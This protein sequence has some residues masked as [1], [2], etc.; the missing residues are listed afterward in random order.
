MS[1]LP[2]QVAADTRPGDM[3]CGC[4]WCDANGR[5]TR[6]DAVLL[7][8]TGY[9]RADLVEMKHVWDVLSGIDIPLAGDSG[10]A[11]PRPGRTAIVS[12]LKLIAK[13]GTQSDV[14]VS[15]RRVVR[16]SGSGPGLCFTIMRLSGLWSGDQQL[17]ALQH[18][19]QA[20]RDRL[21]T[22]LESTT[23]SVIV[24]DRNW[25][26]TYA[27]QRAIAMIGRGRS[28][29]GAN[30][31]DVY[32]EA[33]TSV[34]EAR[35]LACLARRTSLEF[36][37]FVPWLNAWLEVHLYPTDDSITAFFRDIS[38]AKA[39]E[40]EQLKTREWVAHMARHDPLTGLPNR[41]LF[42]DQLD[43]AI[44]SAGR[45][46]PFVVLLLDV[47]RFGVVNT[48]LG[49]GLGDMVLRQIGE[50]LVA[51]A[52]DI[53]IVARLGSDEFG[54]ILNGV[55]RPDDAAV[56]ANRIL[57]VMADPITVDGNTV[58]VGVSIGIACGISDGSTS[59]HLLAHADIALHQVKTDGGAGFRFASRQLDDQLRVRERTK[60]DLQ[61]ALANDDLFLQY[62]PIVQLASRRIVGVEALVR[63]RHRVLGIQ[64]PNAFIPI[65]EDSGLIVP[66]GRWVLRQAARD[67]ARLPTDIVVSV[68]LS[69]IQF[70][71]DDVVAVVMAALSEAN[72]TG[73][74]LMLEITETALLRD[75]AATLAVLTRL[76]ALGVQLA[77]DD[78]G[79]GF[80][81]LG[82]L[83]DYPFDKIKLDR[84]FVR[85][86]PGANKSAAISAAIAKLG[87]G[88]GITTV[89]EGIETEAQYDLLK[90]QGYDEGQGFL[91]SQ[92]VHADAIIALIQQRA[93]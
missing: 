65:A 89:A 46:I 60:Q 11:L 32:P 27:N 15:I 17:E 22:T 75:A 43:R 41:V 25:H 70:A 52:R 80:S 92:P 42:R 69:P 47:D 51:C 36:D 67:A 30:L 88:L 77:L 26:V 37:E 49:Y 6:A 86:L 21:S 13:D 59:D 74:R 24:I 5:I 38:K 83:Q 34:F 4:L 90:V 54:L 62:Q 76:K 31:C 63:W 84:A 23:D 20:M 9:R 73:E 78:F 58:T 3:P 40:Q 2:D 33:R 7:A 61:Q 28:L 8:W 45:G 1:A 29:I 87:H 68:N 64:S 48:M 39:F 10:A 93:L 53:D 79:T 91:F 71:R 50:R 85:N 82:Y 14:F 18:Q 16:R 44:A 72:I 66:L 56:V 57:T 35:C 55:D 81:S 19:L 12:D